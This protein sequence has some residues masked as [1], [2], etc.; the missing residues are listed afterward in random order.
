M[1]K[2]LGGADKDTEIRDSLYTVVNERWALGC[3]ITI[4]AILRWNVDRLREDEQVARTIGEAVEGFRKTIGEALIRYRM[5][6]FP[7]TSASKHKMDVAS[8]WRTVRVLIAPAKTTGPIR[9]VF[10]DGGSRGNPGPGGS[11][12][13]WVKHYRSTM[14]NTPVRAAA[15]ALG[16]PTTTNNVAEFVGLHWLLTRAAEM[17]WKG[18]QVVGDSALILGLLARRQMP[19]ARK[20]QHCHQL[21]I[22]LADD[23]EVERWTHHYRRH[24]KIADWLA[25]FAMDS[26]KVA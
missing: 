14:I 25:N 26:C 17:G 13:V 7:H 2:G 3:A 24:N 10:F 21:T 22:R 20:L 6:L 19:K 16:R 4:T 1:A 8:H 11:G 9:V 18:V 5:A 23:C 15:T 12:S